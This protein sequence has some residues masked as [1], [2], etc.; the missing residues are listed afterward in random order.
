[1]GD[2]LP[3]REPGGPEWAARG[4]AM[5]DTSL[6][7]C[8][9][10]TVFAVLFAAGFLF[11]GLVLPSIGILV[12]AGVPG[13]WTFARARQADAAR[14]TGWRTAPISRLAAGGGRR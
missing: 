4:T 13:Y 12:A 11:S 2:W 9:A 10:S 8:V 5:L 3:P 6:R 7:W 1:M 14:R